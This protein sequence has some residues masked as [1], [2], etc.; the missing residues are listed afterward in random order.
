M[1]ENKNDLIIL[2]SIFSVLAVVPIFIHD[3]LY[4]MNIMIM[5]LIW[6]VVAASWDL[7]MG[8]AGIFTFGQIAFFVIGAYGSGIISQHFGISPWLSMGIGSLIAGLAGLLVSLP[9][10]KLEGAYV[11][12]VTFAV[13]MILEPFLKSNTGRLI[14]TGGTQG[15]MDIPPLSFGGVA[16]TSFEPLPWFYTAFILALFCLLIIYKMIHSYWGLAFLALRDSERFANLLGVD[17]FKYK[18]IVF[19]ITAALTGL[20]GGF[21][22]HYVS[23]LS[24][25]MLGLDLF[26]MLMIILVIGGI[27]RFPGAVIGA[28]IVTFGY[29]LLRP[30]GTYRPVIIGALTVLLI[31]RFPKGAMGLS[32]VKGKLL[33]RK[34]TLSWKR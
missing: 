26:L 31:L 23:M 21:Y 9:C 6:S 28:L 24:T 25:R 5:C 34:Y 1:T 17:G 19:S 2:L 8:F 7:I 10:L 13:H 29:E 27:G 12:L 32:L 14:G 30:V 18:L 3:N 4:L 20:I 15:L 33:L 16:F 22:A 11:A